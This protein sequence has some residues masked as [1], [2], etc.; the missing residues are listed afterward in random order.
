MGGAFLFSCRKPPW[1]LQK[2]GM[3][4]HCL[5]Q[6]WPSRLVLFSCAGCVHTSTGNT[7]SREQ[8]QERWR[9]CGGVTLGLCTEGWAG[10]GISREQHLPLSRLSSSARSC[11]VCSATAPMA[12]AHSSQGSCLEA[13]RCHQPSVSTASAAKPPRHHHG[14]HVLICAPHGLGHGS[15]PSRCCRG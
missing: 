14:P 6:G 2:H 11:C 13:R 8:R 1:C 12:K 10:A 3:S 4:P 15:V 9:S 5:G 7:D